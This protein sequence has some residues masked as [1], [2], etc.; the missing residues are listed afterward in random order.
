M[1]QENL[2]LVRGLFEMSHR[3]LD[4]LKMGTAPLEL[5]YD[6]EVVF[7]LT[8]FEME[9]LDYEYRG[10]DGARRFWKQLLSTWSGLEW[11]AELFER[12]DTVVA[13]LDQRSRAERSGEEHYRRYAQLL[14]FHDSR[15]V[16]WKPYADPADALEAAGIDADLP[17]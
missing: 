5:V 4:L 10:L 8:D 7:D 16:F 2:D 6:R 13:V 9:G 1:S 11:E 3:G 17:D 15:I 14:R 12:G